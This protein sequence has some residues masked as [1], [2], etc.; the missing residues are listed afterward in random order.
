MPLLTTYSTAQPETKGGTRRAPPVPRRWR[1]IDGRWRRI[2]I[3]LIEHERATMP[4]L[5]NYLT[6]ERCDGCGCA[7]CTSLHDYWG[8][9]DEDKEDLC[10]RT[11]QRHH[12]AGLCGTCHRALS[13]AQ[14]DIRVWQIT[15]ELSA[16]RAS[17]KAATP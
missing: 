12:Y 7:L 9:T 2:P 13:P 11:G 4:P 6:S 16:T 10:P 8:A 15:H 14:Q 1:L 3:V 17:T 5:T